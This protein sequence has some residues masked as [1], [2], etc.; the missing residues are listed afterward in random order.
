MNNNI[1]TFYFY[2]FTY[3]TINLLYFIDFTIF[4]NYNN[5]QEIVIIYGGF[6]NGWR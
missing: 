1:L 6:N 4:L 5:N 2:I 3:L